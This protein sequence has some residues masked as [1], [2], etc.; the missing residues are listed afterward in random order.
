MQTQFQGVLPGATIGFMSNAMKQAIA[1]TAARWVVEEGLAYGPAKQKAVREMGLSSRQA[2]PDNDLLEAEV[3]AYLQCFHADTQPAQLR[4]LREHALTWMVRLQAF[5]PHLSGA[6]WRGT[7]TR[8]SDIHLQLF[9]D[10][11]KQAEWALLDQGVRFDVSEVNGF[12]GEKVAAL[13]IQ[14]FCPGLA[15][16]V[17]VHLMVHDHD[18]L[19]GGLLPDK[20]GRTDR[21]DTAALRQ[22]LDNAA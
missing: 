8:H 10:D 21:G 20:Q 9:C 2:L 12:R 13:S 18:D 17:G 19:R 14:S 5:R 15:E 22:L 3:M 4:A 11:S 16:T 7:A 1:A 6:V